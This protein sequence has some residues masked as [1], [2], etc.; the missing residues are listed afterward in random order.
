[1]VSGDADISLVRSRRVGVVGYGSQGRAHALNLRDSGCR[2]QVGLYQ[3]SASWERAESDGFEVGEVA[4]ISSGADLIS[5][6]LPDQVHHV[7]FEESIR[8][9]LAAGAMLLLAHGFSIQ[10]GEIRP[11][12]DV[13]VALVAPVG[14]G[15]MVRRLFLEGSGVP[16]VMAVDQDATGRA[17]ALALSYAAAIG[18]TR[19]GVIPSTFQE[20]TET[21]LFG[22]QV[23]VCGGLTELIRHAYE[24]L[25]EA[26][27]QREI[28]YFESL[29]QVKLLADLIY[30][31]GIAFMHS[32]ISRTA[33]YGAHLSGP[34]VIDE[35]TR[36]AMRRVLG[37]IQSGEFARRWIAEYRAGSPA[38]DRMR[39]EDRDHPIEQVTREVRS[40]IEGG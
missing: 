11:P 19:V 9:Q 35:H 4:A 15:D 3:G 16:A 39:Q 28:A 30:Q 22:E 37:D 21:D 38:L 17:R 2:V 32:R 23:V 12:P 36:E 40:L 18:S 1:V 8:P 6:M 29:H 31:G 26:G 13:D 25:V 10:Y 5:L 20:E 27:Y 14:P 34:R 24:T 7:V 33:E